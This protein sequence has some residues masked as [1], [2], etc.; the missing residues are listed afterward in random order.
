MPVED[1]HEDPVGSGEIDEDE[2]YWDL[3]EAAALEDPSSTMLNEEPKG[4]E[5][6]PEVHK[7]VQKFLTAHPAPPQPLTGPLECPVII[8]QR[9]P[10]TKARGFVRAYAPALEDASIDQDTWM[11]FLKIFHKSQQVGAG[12]KQPLVPQFQ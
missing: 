4:D 10:H 8:P 2:A 5:R 11:E 9:R 6:K 1:T 7:L 3:D 12:Y